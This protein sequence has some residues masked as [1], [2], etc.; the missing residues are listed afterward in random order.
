MAKLIGIAVHFR[1]GTRGYPEP[2]EDE[3]LL[4][5]SIYSILST[6]PGER[7][8]RPTFGCYLRYLVFA[9]MGKAAAVRA[10]A[11]AREAI[12]KFEKRVQVDDIEFEKI[13]DNRINLIVYWRVKGTIED[14]RSTVVPF[15]VR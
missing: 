12:K 10:R 6:V 13:D 3:E 8:R 7:V 9:N 1:F 14:A 2:A 15:G 4:G 11:E 5:D